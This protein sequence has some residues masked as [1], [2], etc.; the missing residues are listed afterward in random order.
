LDKNDSKF[1]A[2]LNRYLADFAGRPTPL[3]YA[4]RL[5]NAY[6]VK[7]YIKRETSCTAAHTS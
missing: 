3:Y 2:E 6:G 4:K 7:I 1:V 5:G